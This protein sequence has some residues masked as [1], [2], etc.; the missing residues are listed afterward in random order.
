MVF[1]PI[2]R[3]EGIVMTYTAI[4]GSTDTSLSL[5]LTKLARLQAGRVVVTIQ[6]S[7]FYSFAQLSLGNFNGIN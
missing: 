6:V 2:L 5:H 1:V 4:W 7:G 3:P